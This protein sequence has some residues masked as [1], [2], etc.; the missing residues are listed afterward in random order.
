M[1][2]AAMKLDKNG[3]TA[4]TKDG[5]KCVQFEHTLVLTD[6]GVIITTDQG[7]V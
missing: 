6:N 4:R 7:D 2:S 3:W 1:G 5:S